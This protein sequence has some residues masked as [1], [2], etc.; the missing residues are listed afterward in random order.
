[1]KILLITSRDNFFGG[2]FGTSYREAGGPAIAD[3][4]VLPGRSDLSYPFVWRGYVAW[5]LLGIA[6]IITVLG[7]RY[8]PWL[9]TESERAGGLHLDWVRAMSSPGTRVH[10]HNNARPQ[11]LLAA[12][13]AASPDLVVSIGAPVIFKRKLLDVPSL[14]AIN[15]HNGR[16]PVYRGH[17]GT[18]WEVLEGEEFSY[19][20]IHEMVPQV[21]AGG[22]LAFERTTVKD[23]SSFCQLL[24]HKKRSGGKA[25]AEVLRRTVERDKFPEPVPWPIEP[26]D[27]NYFGWPTV[28]D[29]RRFSW[30]KIEK[31]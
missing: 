17:F 7:S 15:V 2:V 20:C 18:F 11:D 22:V 30:R 31:H 25:L 26:G 24:I 6:G 10:Y 27:K 4:V 3:I 16:I 28:Q 8:C 1:M 23:H 21:D 13:Q 29:I 12:V 5:K 14:G 19:T 9:L